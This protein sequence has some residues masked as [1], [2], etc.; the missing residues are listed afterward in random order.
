M[1][2]RR[3]TRNCPFVRKNLLLNKFSMI[4]LTRE[5]IDLFIISR[6]EIRR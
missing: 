5:V 2:V 4:G 3:E 6:L 1:R